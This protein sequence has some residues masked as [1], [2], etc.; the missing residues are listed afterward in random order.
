MNID[1][2][3]AET[4]SGTLVDGVG[5]LALTQSGAGTTTLTNSGNSYSEETTVS[6]GILQIGTS[7]VAG[8]MG[9]KELR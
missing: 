6:G 8:S 3:S 5:K 9:A 1:T 2:A 4:L 7:S